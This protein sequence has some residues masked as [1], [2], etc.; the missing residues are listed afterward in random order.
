[1]STER[2][3]VPTREILIRAV[4]PKPNGHDTSRSAAL[5]RELAA[6]RAAFIAA[7]KRKS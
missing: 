4:L 2:P 5:A 6:V 7:A 3:L 1:M